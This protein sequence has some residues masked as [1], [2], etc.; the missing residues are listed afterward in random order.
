MVPVDNYV[1][2]QSLQINT[3]IFNKGTR[4]YWDSL[5]YFMWLPSG[6]P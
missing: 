5:S 6:N 4:I 2:V 3:P 1:E